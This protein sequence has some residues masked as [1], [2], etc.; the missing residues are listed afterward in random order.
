LGQR[1]QLS[2]ATLPPSR[3]PWLTIV[4]IVPTLPNFFPDR[5]DDPV[6]YVPMDAEQ[7][8]QRVV[9]VIVR[10]AG[11]PGPGVKSAATTALRGE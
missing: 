1:I 2:G 3:A 5:M 6:V 4:G 7:A 9:S 11:A 8:P 10:A